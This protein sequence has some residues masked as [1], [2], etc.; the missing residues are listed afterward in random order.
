MPLDPRP[1]SIRLSNQA[2]KERVA[3]QNGGVDA[4]KALGFVLEEKGLPHEVA[5]DREHHTFLT[6]SEQKEDEGLLRK[7]FE[8]IKTG[9]L[10]V[11]AAPKEIPRLVAQGGGGGG[12]GRAAA[13]APFDPYKSQFTSTQPKPK[14]FGAKSVTETKLEKLKAQRSQLDGG[15][16]DRNLRIYPADVDIPAA[17]DNGTGAAAAAGSSS[18]SSSSS[19]L[20]AGPLDGSSGGGY[21]GYGGGE[22]DG[23]SDASLAAAAMAARMKQRK[24][25]EDAPFKTKQ[26]QKRTLQRCS[27]P[28]SPHLDLGLNPPLSVQPPTLPSLTLALTPALNSPLSAHPTFPPLPPNP[29]SQPSD[30]RAGG[31]REGASLQPHPHPSSVP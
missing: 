14:N 19:G 6:L 4:L 31:P 1:R 11:G 30:A 10:E 12:G 23:A 8:L 7:A 21:G 27:A 9:A 15:I 16:P 18:S 13:A 24:K 26:V 25:D 22:G 20:S 29:S 2:F 5:R 3:G 28:P 17:V